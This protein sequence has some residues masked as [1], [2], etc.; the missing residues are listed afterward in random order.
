[1]NSYLKQ[2][3]SGLLFVERFLIT[4]SDFLVHCDEVVVGCMSLGI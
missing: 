1:M 2:S 4:H 3:V